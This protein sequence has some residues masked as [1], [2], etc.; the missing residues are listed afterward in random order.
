MGTVAF[1]TAVA[2]KLGYTCRL[3]RKAW[4]SGQRVV[5]TGSTE[6]LASLDSLLWTFDKDEFLPH[7]RLLAGRPLADHLGRTPV[8]LAD[9]AA[10]VAAEAGP[11]E[12]L[13]NLGPAPVEGALAYAKVFEVVADSA[14]EI[15][16]GRQR[17]RGYLAAGITPTN[18]VASAA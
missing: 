13:I 4:R 7:A 2:D 3:V 5:V 8:L 18:H 1:H 14:D 6:Q 16:S 11:A 15:Q 9:V 12:V 17:W 10:D